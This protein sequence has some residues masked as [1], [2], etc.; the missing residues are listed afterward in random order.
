MRPRCKDD[1]RQDAEMTLFHYRLPKKYAD[2]R[3]PLRI[4]LP[5]APMQV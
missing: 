5:E 1:E 2:P 3:F 4:L